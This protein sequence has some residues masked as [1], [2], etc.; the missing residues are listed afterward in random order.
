MALSFELLGRVVRNFLAENKPGKRRLAQTLTFGGLGSQDRLFDDQLVPALKVR[1]ALRLRVP[2][3][4]AL[5][6]LQRQRC[7]GK[8]DRGSDAGCNNGAQTPARKTIGRFVGAGHID[9]IRTGSVRM[10]C[11][12][13]KLTVKVFVGH[14]VRVM[15]AD[16]R[17][18]ARD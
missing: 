9:K 16:G 12:W 1:V 7:N 6:A 13:L 3:F 11:W 10:G 15:F 4:A 5:F 17:F 2:Y 18:N 8:N 14:S